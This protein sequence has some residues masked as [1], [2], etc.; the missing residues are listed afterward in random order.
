MLIAVTG[1]LKALHFGWQSLMPQ[2]KLFWVNWPTGDDVDTA[3]ED[4]PVSILM[5]H[6]D[7]PDAVSSVFDYLKVEAESAARANIGLILVVAPSSAEARP[8]INDLRDHTP[9]TVEW[10]P[11]F[12][13]LF[14]PTGGPDGLRVVSTL[15][16]TETVLWVR[17]QDQLFRLVR[18][19]KSPRWPNHRASAGY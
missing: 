14:E 12:D 6:H 17:M 9:Y 2:T 18:E 7:L 15:P 19:E 10:A 1:G 11:A 13:T 8:I 3:L 4:T 16:A 5:V